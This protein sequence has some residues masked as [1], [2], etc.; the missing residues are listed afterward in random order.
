MSAT[1]PDG[2]KSTYGATGLP[3]GLAIN[4]TTGAISGALSYTSAGTTSVTVTASDGTLIATTSFTWTVSNV[5]RP[6]A[7]TAIAKITSAEHDTVTLSVSATDPDGDP[8]TYGATGLPQGLAINPATGA[9]SGTLSYTSAGT[10]S[11]TVTVSDGTLSASTSFTWSVTNVDRA[12]VLTPIGNITTVTGAAVAVQMTATD[13][14]ND[15]ITYGA[16]GLP[17]G[18][19][20]NVTTG[21]ISGTPTTAGS[22]PVTAVALDSSQSGVSAFTWTI[23]PPSGAG[24]VFVQANSSQQSGAA[25]TANI[26]FVSPQLN[27]DLNIVVVA[28]QD[29]TNAQVS[30]VTDNA[31]N[32]YV[33]AG[34]ATTVPGLGT[35][36]VY[37]AGNVGGAAAGT[38]AVSVLFSS[39]V[40]LFDVRVAEYG[41]VAPANVL[42]AAVST[43]GIGALADSGSG[44]T[45]NPHDLLLGA[46]FAPS[47][48]SSA[49]A[50]YTGRLVTSVGSLLEDAASTNIGSF[51]ATA[52]LSPSG[53][54][55]AQ[56][57][58][59]KNTNHPPALS[60]P[61]DQTAVVQSNVTLQI[62]A[63]DPDGDALNYIVSG[64]PAGLSINATTGLIS[65]TLS[66]SS[67]GSYNVSVTVSDGRLSVTGAF[68]WIVTS[69][70]VGPPTLARQN[71]FDGDGKADIA[72]Y[73]GST[74]TWSM[75]KSSSNYLTTSTIALGASGDVPVSGDFD[76]DGKADIAVYRPSTGVWS[77]KLSGSNYTSTLTATLGS[78]GDIPVPGDYDGDGLTDVAVFSPATGQ[79]H[80]LTSSSNFTASSTKTLGA[81]G[82]IPV[83]G[84]Y[85]GDG[86]TDVGVYRPSTGQWLILRSTSNDTAPSLVSTWGMSTD[87]PVVGDYDGDGKSDIA[88]YRPSTGTWFIHTSSSNFTAGVAYTWGGGAGIPVPADYDGDGRTDLAVY[89]AATGEWSILQ[90]MPGFTVSATV[91]LG[92]GSDVPALNAL[93]YKAMNSTRT[94]STRAN[95]YDGDRAA[96]IAIYRPTTG[97][98]TI[99]TSGSGYTAGLTRTWGTSA[100]LPVP[101]DYD[102]DG[103]TDIAV[104][105]ATSGTWFILRSSSDYA[106]GVSY[107]LGSRLEIPVPGDYDGDGK[108]DVAVFS[109]TTGAWTILTSSSNYTA[110]TILTL[111]SSGDIP[112]PGDY[113]GDGQADVAVF[114]PST[115][116]WLILT[117]SSNYT[118]SL[119]STWGGSGDVPVV[120]DYDGDGKTDIAVYRPSTGT[121]FV[122]TSSS[123][124][125]TGFTYILGNAGDIPVPADYDGDGRTD[126][127]VYHPA[128]GSWTVLES[129]A[130]YASTMTMTLG[131]I[132]D[133]PGVDEVGLVDAEKS[134]R[135]DSTRQRDYDGD[136]KADVAVYR[137]STGAWAI[138]QSSAGYSSGVSVTW[139]VATDIPVPGDYNGDGKT[140]IAVYTSFLR[141][142]VHPQIIDQLC[143]RRSLRARQPHGG[144]STG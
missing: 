85:D 70:H 2:D 79:W 117:S 34:S 37:H 26:P 61:A 41:G 88:V 133:A 22:Y 81:A 29:A 96:D 39:A 112:V 101:G 105:R 14:D 106:S 7:I 8:I 143:L 103:K 115:G 1:D 64:L 62:Q 142:L 28:W 32:S 80:I 52:A 57:V 137:P 93:A 75:L 36:A 25:T 111:G 24:V 139:G 31:G 114:R 108:T 125:T 138:L 67:A 98:W 87:L 11:V 120:G 40:S 13:P 104:Y 78:P 58:A 76:G 68:A 45:T 74:G 48:V 84:D 44:T 69:L 71:D 12:P 65:G 51:N 72:I 9:I 63:S 91:V 94:D 10:S 30:A 3:Q 121:W 128:N 50:G 46:V 135:N 131:S 23:T 99:R 123:G 109:T 17:P 19:S 20:L 55:I 118:T 73:R 47:V 6:P 86:K 97:D 113:D 130:G 141:L 95:D 140:D 132:A 56:L 92:S 144:C 122:Q 89:R 66:A 33:L 129:S 54:W 18:V 35:Q 83:P 16:S 43:S 42:D 4:P 107:T 102:G 124:F 38:N 134:L 90:S 15:T 21:L 136:G 77:I 53:P 60:I 49:G 126:I 116:Q 127:A 119:N 27:G 100:D 110:K 5:N 82:D 59:F